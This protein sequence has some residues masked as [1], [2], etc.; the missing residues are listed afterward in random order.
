MTP[1]SHLSSYPVIRAQKQR[2]IV[3]FIALVA[4]VTIMLAA[5]AL[6][7]SVD[8]NTVIAG[9]LAFKQSATTAGDGG[10]RSAI[11]WM[12]EK[13]TAYSG[14]DAFV[15]ASHPFNND[16][17]AAG[18]YSALHDRTSTFVT[19]DSTWVDSKSMKVNGGVKDVAGNEMRYIIERMCAPG[20][21]GMLLSTANCLFTNAAQ[22]GES[23]LG[24]EQVP[25]KGGVSPVNRVTIRITGPR[26]TISY[27]Q[28]FIY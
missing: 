7:R 22:G 2:G 5:T 27:I 1:C 20:T 9:N 15:V 11:T 3:L 18:Y 12:S 10:L 4:L 28:A 13:N 8:T 24:G 17:P 16:N 26:N 21:A 23:N 19:A 6:I 25:F 14:I